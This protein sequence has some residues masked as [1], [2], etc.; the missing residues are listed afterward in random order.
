M[1][2][3]FNLPTLSSVLSAKSDT[4]MV[5]PTAYDESR[6]LALPTELL[7]HIFQSC[8][9]FEAAAHLAATSRYLYG[10]WR[11]HRTPIYNALAP[12]TILG[13]SALRDMLA[14]L[15][16]VPLETQPLTF[17]H[18]VRVV[19]VSRISNDLLK[20]YQEEIQSY[21]HH[22]P[23]VPVDLSPTE[24]RRFVRAQ[25]QILGLLSLD[26]AKQKQRFKDLDL[27]TL[28]LLSDLLCVFTPDVITDENLREM[29]D[30]NAIGYRYL[31]R[32]LRAQR[33]KV[34]RRLYNHGYR[35][36]SD[37]PYEQGGRHAWWCD[38]QQQ[39]FKDMLTG[40][41][42]HDG[43]GKADMSKVRDDMWYDSADE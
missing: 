35:P 4:T 16:D 3:L 32:E 38:R 18:I 17:A 15:G 31:Q 6:L 14:D 20:V 8:P 25:Y 37:T 39:T 10:I 2:S 24:K 43:D 36:I 34:F 22:D 23:Q 7:V 40:R 13:Y 19:E 42:F 1:G 11:Q 41:V 21:T 9:S 12:A 27:K 30:S 33:N 29:L 5:V 28:F 26:Q